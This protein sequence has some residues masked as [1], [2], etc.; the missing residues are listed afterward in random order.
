MSAAGD[1][2]DAVAP[3]IRRVGPVGRSASS[4]AAPMAADSAF[5]V[6]LVTLWHQVAQAG[7][8]VGFAK[9]VDRADIARSAVPM[10]EDLR[11]G[12]MLGVAADQ[13]RRLVG[14]GLLRPGVG[15]RAH[16]GRLELL[17]VEPALTG[18]GLG[19]ALLETLL[20]T[21]RERGLDRLTVEFAQDERV[22]RFFERFGFTTWGRRPGWQR[23][24]AGPD[25]DEV[26]MGVA[27]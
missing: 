27:W 13:G 22:G 14:V 11:Q 15:A 21:A 24:A 23:T 16:T 1:A 17:A 2:L 20:A 10:V 9:E 8:V 7:G 19:R 12:R 25:R 5:G 18:C 4:P 6:A 26:I 3:T